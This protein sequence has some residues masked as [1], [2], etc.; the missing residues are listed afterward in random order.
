MKNIKKI[1]SLIKIAN[2][3]DAE[4][5]FDMADIMDRLIHKIAQE[6]YKDG[7]GVVWT[8]S[9]DPKNPGNIL[10]TGGGMTVSIAPG[11]HPGTVPHATPQK[12]QQEDSAT[13]EQAPTDNGGF[14]DTLHGWGKSIGVI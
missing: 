7:S 14:V 2:D 11:L 4:G 5:N 8:S 3:Y 1:V 13:N 12:P 10:W 9:P 6:T